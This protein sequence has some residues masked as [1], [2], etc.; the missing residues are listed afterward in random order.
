MQRPRFAPLCTYLS[1]TQDCLRRVDF[2]LGH[3]SG[4]FAI[5]GCQCV[6]LLVTHKV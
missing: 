2:D 6:S 1:L 5:I 4:I 3:G